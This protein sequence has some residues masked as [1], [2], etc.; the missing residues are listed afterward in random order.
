MNNK[1]MIGEYEERR[2]KEDWEGKMQD[3]MIETW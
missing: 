1:I 2:V 3:K